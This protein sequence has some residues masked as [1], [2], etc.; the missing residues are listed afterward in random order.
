MKNK[1][2]LAPKKFG[3]PKKSLVESDIRLILENPQRAK[4]RSKDHRKD[5]RAK[6]WQTHIA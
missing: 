3:H 4:F 5:N 6:I 2:P 1:E